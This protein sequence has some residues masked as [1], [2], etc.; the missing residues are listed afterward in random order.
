MEARNLIGQILEV[1]GKKVRV[2]DFKSSGTAIELNIEEVKE[3]AEKKKYLLS[4][5]SR[6][7]LKG[8]HPDLVRL[9]EEAIKESP[10]DFRITQGLRTAEYQNKLYQ[11]GRTTPGP[12]ITN[13]DGYRTK[14]N[15]QAKSDGLGHAVDIFVCGKYDENGKY[16]KYTSEEGYET[17][18]L[19]AVANHIKIVAKKMGISVEWGGDWSKFKD[20]PHFQV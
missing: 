10:F 16:I 6:E 1:E 13:C 20:Y 2:V 11:Q 12:K 15:H 7:K 5:A 17:K 19:V 8:V 9:F 3:A 14:S 18:K 4:E